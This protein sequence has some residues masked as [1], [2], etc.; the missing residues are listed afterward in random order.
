MKLATLKIPVADL[1]R[2]NAFYA[3]LFEREPVFTAA[4]FGW[5]QFDLE[6]LPLALYDPSKS[7]HGGEPGHDLD[8]HLASEAIKAVRDRIVPHAPDATIHANADGSRSLELS[9]PDGNKLTIM[10][11]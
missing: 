9:D 6:G 2:A 8:F 5:T 10:A 1:E 3:V 11:A 7:N 4:E